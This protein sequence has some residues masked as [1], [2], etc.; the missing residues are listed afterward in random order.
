MSQDLKHKWE[1]PL[2]VTV[3]IIMAPI[4][5]L[6]AMSG[7]GLF[8]YQCYQWLRAG[9]WEEM[10]VAK[11]W[12]V[13]FKSWPPFSDWGGIYRLEEDMPMSLFLIG[14]A[15]V[16]FWLT[17]KIFSFPSE[18]EEGGPSY[19]VAA[20]GRARKRRQEQRKAEQEATPMELRLMSSIQLA[21]YTNFE[22]IIERRD[23]NYEDW[24]RNPIQDL[25]KAEILRIR[26]EI[27]RK[28]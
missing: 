7:I 12:V 18:M 9:V 28:E 6:F 13:F 23:R 4:Y 10:S 5:G 24:E 15:I 11:G 17:F 25:S 21:E 19:S 26:S 22:A 14:A 20:Q 2:Q 16:M 27:E 1:N 8:V 3:H